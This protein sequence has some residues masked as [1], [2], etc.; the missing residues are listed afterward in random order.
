MIKSLSYQKN[1]FL[2]LYKLIYNIQKIEKLIKANPTQII[3]SVSGFEENYPKY[4]GNASWAIF[5]NNIELLYKLINI[6]KPKTQISFLFHLYRDNRNDLEKI[7][8]YLKR[9][10]FKVSPSWA[11]LNPYNLL[12]YLEYN[13]INHKIKSVLDSLAWD[14]E[15]IIPIIKSEIG[16]PCL[17]QRLFPIINWD[18]SV[19][20]C[21]L[22]YNKIH[23]NYLDISYNKLLELRHN[24]QICK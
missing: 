2:Y 16:K 13:I 22:Y 19:F 18:L 14:F 3:I 24:Q 11:Y 10:N 20:Q 8:E 17:C 1:M 9:Y 23:N 6:Y 21:H 12:Y 4:Y 15:K 5:K 7:K